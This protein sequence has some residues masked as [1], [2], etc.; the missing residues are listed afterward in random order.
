MR[1]RETAR[2][3]LPVAVALRAVIVRLT[4]ATAYVHSTLG[5]P[6]STANAAGYVALAAAMVVPIP[7]ASRF[8]RLV[9]PAFAVYAIAVP[10]PSHVAS[11][12]ARPERR[13]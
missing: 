8:R 5:G 2:S 7:F 12:A 11:W 1:T 3:A 9:R 13:A 4:L 6:L 10:S